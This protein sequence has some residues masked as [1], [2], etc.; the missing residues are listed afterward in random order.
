MLLKQKDKTAE[1]M[2]AEESKKISNHWYQAYRENKHIDWNIHTTEMRRFFLIVDN[3]LAR[4]GI[5]PG[6]R[7]EVLD[8]QR[9]TEEESKLSHNAETSERADK[10]CSH[11]YISVG[12]R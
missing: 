7:L 8:F 4:L 11:F 6:K 10:L 12:H 1:R 5:E 3:R 9:I 2:I